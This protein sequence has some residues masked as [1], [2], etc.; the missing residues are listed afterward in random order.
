[1]EKIIRKNLNLFDLLA[2]EVSPDLKRQQHTRYQLL[3]YKS[4]P[5][6]ILIKDAAFVITVDGQD[7]LRVW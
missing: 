7:K 2:E 1:M 5:K 4:A 3:N 6:R